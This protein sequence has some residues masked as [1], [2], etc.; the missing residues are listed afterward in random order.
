LHICI[1]CNSCQEIE[2]RT[3]G[4]LAAVS[5]IKLCQR[6]IIADDHQSVISFKNEIGFGNK[7]K[8]P[9]SAFFD[10]NHLNIKA[11]GQVDIAQRLSGPAPDYQLLY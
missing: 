5:G 9:V 7:G 8:F 6:P 2:N 3:R 4:E 10:G 1:I 11:V